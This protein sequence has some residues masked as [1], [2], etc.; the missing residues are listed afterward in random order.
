MIFNNINQSLNTNPLKII[1]ISLE[2]RIRS[3]E[4]NA[5]LVAGFST[6]S[7]FYATTH[8]GTILYPDILFYHFPTRSMMSGSGSGGNLPS[9]SNIPVTS[10]SPHPGSSIPADK[11]TSQD[12]PPIDKV[13]K[14]DQPSSS[15]PW[16]HQQQA[17]GPS[18]SSTPFSPAVGSSTTISYNPN[19]ISVPS[20]N[21]A[22]SQGFITDR[23]KANRPDLI[24]KS[25]LQDSSIMAAPSGTTGLRS[26]PLQTHSFSTPSNSTSL[27]SP[28][29][30]NR[31]D[32]RFTPGKGYT[33]FDVVVIEK[34]DVNTG[35]KTKIS[36]VVA[37]NGQQVP[38][39]EKS[40]TVLRDNETGKDVAV[41]TSAKNI[42]KGNVL[43][44]NDNYKG[45]VDNTGKPKKQYMRT[46]DQP[47][48]SRD[49][50]GMKENLQA[51]NHAKK[52][53]SVIDQ[54]ISQSQVSEKPA[55][56]RYDKDAPELYHENGSPIYD[57]NGTE[58]DYD[59]K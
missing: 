37:G 34:T 58:I 2:R 17:Q 53:D 45:Q 27:L 19:A 59:K 35:Q 14:P 39:H 36:E 41:L 49:A 52:H 47:R 56:V 16:V 8:R 32:K 31:I 10:N 7:T 23:L 38:L 44:S 40:H 33:A 51:T 55:I 6:L 12:I 26:F 24:T 46:Y 57:E 50:K 13:V 48:D 11:P 30:L 18:T 20:Q 21:S 4:L 28:L 15:N 3:L 9:L 22:N 5:I 1:N 42:A 54:H 25:P 29:E 43:I